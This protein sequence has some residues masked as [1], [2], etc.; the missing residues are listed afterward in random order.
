MKMH[1]LSGGRLRM[2]KSIYLPDADRQEMIDLPVSCVLLRHRQGNV[3]F[4]TGCHPSVAADAE[5]RWG[6]MAKAMTLVSKPEENVVDELRAVGLAPDDI[7]VVINSHF[8]TDHCGCNEFFKRATVVCHARELDD[9]RGADA[10]KKGYVAADWDHPM[11]FDTIEGER[12]LFGD[13]RIH[14]F[15]VPGHTPGAIAAWV[16]LDRAGEFLLAADAVSLRASLER[17]IVPR[18]TWDA[19]LY[20]KSLAEIRRLEAGGATVICGHDIEQ[21]ASLKKGVDAYE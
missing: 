5:A 20:L 14:L 16:R 17:D 8:H 2:K 1:L 18:N 15:P 7:D 4:D 12:D 6:G 3:L 19:D 9:A 11:P 13:A 10:V 21:W